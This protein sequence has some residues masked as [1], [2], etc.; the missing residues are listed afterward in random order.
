MKKSI[1]EIYAL[2]VCFLMV[3]V[4]GF[5]LGKAVYS[6]IE[7]SNPQ[8]TLSSYEYGR[9]QTND[10]FCNSNVYGHI[11][12]LCDKQA[13]DQ[14][15]QLRINALNSAVSAEQ[16]S[17]YQSLIIAIIVLTISLIIFVLHWL[18]AK[19]ARQER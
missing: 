2:A 9:L 1:L 5:S 7:I 6:I 12:T 18:L 11:K 15:T 19:R 4:T 17:G 10:N 13:T 8:F 3:F 14:I 16:R